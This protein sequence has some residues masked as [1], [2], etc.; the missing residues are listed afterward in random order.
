MT[1]Y[2]TWQMLNQCKGLHFSW[3]K[4]NKDAS[5][6][7]TFKSKDKSYTLIVKSNWEIRSYGEMYYE[8]IDYNKHTNDTLLLNHAGSDMMVTELSIRGH[9]ELSFLLKGKMEFVIPIYKRS[10]GAFYENILP[11]WIFMEEDKIL[12]QSY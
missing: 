11:N 10:S 3:C 12:A 5:H 2:E 6:T 9:Y 4:K 1:K 7:F 8:S